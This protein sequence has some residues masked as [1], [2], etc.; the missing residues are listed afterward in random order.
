ME[1]I[2]PHSKSGNCDGLGH[3]FWELMDHPL[4]TPYIAH[5][6]FHPLRSIPY[7]NLVRKELVTDADTKQAA[8]SRLETLDT[9]AF[10]T[11]MQALLPR[12][13]KCL[14]VSGDYVEV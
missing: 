11:G 1:I 4:Y 13:E 14:N 10:H 8:N 7:E 3:S 9:Y 6:D 2:G 12:W 5:N